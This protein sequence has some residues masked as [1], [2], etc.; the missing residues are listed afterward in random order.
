MDWA[1]ND[2]D[3]WPRH[4]SDVARDGDRFRTP[5]SLSESQPDMPCTMLC[6]ASATPSTSPAILPP[7]KTFVASARIDFGIAAKC[8]RAIA[9]GLLLILPLPFG[10]CFAHGSPDLRG[11]RHVEAAP[12]AVLRG[13]R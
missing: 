8:S 5:Q 7:R 6:V 11:S 3:E 2:T 9:I 13:H 4:R 1:R 12:G 10:T